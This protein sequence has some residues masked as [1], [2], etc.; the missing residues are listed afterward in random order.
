MPATTLGVNWR[1]D[2]ALVEI[3][4]GDP[5][6]AIYGFRGGDIHTVPQGGRHR[7]MPATTLGVNWRSDR[8]LVETLRAGR[9]DKA[10]RLLRLPAARAVSAPPSR[11]V[12]DRIIANAA[13]H[14]PEA[15]A[16]LRAGR[17]DKANRLLRLPAARAV[18]APPSRGVRDRNERYWEDW[19]RPRGG[20][21]SSG[22][23]RCG[24]TNPAGGYQGRR[25]RDRFFTALWV[26]ER[27]WE[28]WA[29]PRGGNR[30]S[31][32]GRCGRTNPAGGYQAS[33]R[34]NSCSPSVAKMSAMLRPV[35][36]SIA[37]S[38]SSRH[39]VVVGHVPRAPRPPRYV[40]TPAPRRWRRCRR[41]C[42]RSAARSR[43]RCRA[44]AT[45]R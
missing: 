18:S 42:V 40:G 32:A 25:S 26:Y 31:G 7:R 13:R 22:A 39:T 36:C 12:R 41:C 44:G 34:R 28:D 8:A 15:V 10:N 3:L 29:R 37:T 5:K 24:R 16:A 20:N 6:Q 33:I 9:D 27:Y 4:I 35:R 11:G 23:G 30:S 17:D 1:S 2:R 21:R 45:G 43:R 19:A 14:E 38:V